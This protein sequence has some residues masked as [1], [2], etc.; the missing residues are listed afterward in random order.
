MCFAYAQ[1]ILGK[2]YKKPMQ[3]AAL[4]VWG[5]VGGWG[6]MKTNFS[7]CTLGLL[8]FVP[9][10]RS[11]RITYQ[12]KDIFWLSNFTHISSHLKKPVVAEV[13]ISFPLRNQTNSAK[14]QG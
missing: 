10:T 6:G 14:C 12:I 3:T 4:G 8:D 5:G 2:I 13:T 7:L 11:T 9:S 1:T